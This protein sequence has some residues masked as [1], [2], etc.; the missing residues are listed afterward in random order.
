MIQSSSAA[1][2]VIAVPLVIGSPAYVTGF[3]HAFVV[4]ALLAIFGLAFLLEGNGAL[5]LAG[6]YGEEYTREEL[7]AASKRGYVWGAVHNTEVGP[8]DI[9]HLVLTPA[10]VLA[11][12]TKWRFRRADDRGSSRPCARL[13]GQPV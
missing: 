5:L 6:M 12:E 9:D 2:A 1:A 13:R 7:R 3:V 10:G 8:Q 4:M 11:L